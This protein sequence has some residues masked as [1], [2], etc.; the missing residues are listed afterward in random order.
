MKTLQTVIFILLCTVVVFGTY[1]VV[2]AAA[3]P[4]CKPGRFVSPWTTIQPGQS[5]AFETNLCSRPILVF[6]WVGLHVDKPAS[7]NPDTFQPNTDQPGTPIRV[8][9]V[10]STYVYVINAGQ[11]FETIQVIAVP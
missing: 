3:A 7:F 11:V 10:N 2:H 8:E 6:V 5:I 9:G 1:G 4:S